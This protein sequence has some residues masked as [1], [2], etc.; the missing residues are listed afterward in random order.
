VTDLPASV[1]VDT[2]NKDDDD[3]D[4]DDDANYVDYD[5]IDD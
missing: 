5:S 3:D 2:H 1:N 4:D